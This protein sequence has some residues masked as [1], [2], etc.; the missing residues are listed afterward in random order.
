[1]K[2]LC[3]VG[4]ALT[5]FTSQAYGQNRTDTTFNGIKDF[6]DRV[7]TSSDKQNF[8]NKLTAVAQFAGI[9]NNG[10]SFKANLYQLAA[11]KDAYKTSADYFNA[12]PF[13]RNLELDLGATPTDNNFFRYS[14]ASG[15]FTFAIKNNNVLTRNDYQKFIAAPTSGLAESERLQDNLTRLRQ[16]FPQYKV[17]I[18]AFLRKPKN[19]T[20]PLQL[21][22]ILGGLGFTDPAAILKIPA[23]AFKEIGIKAKARSL[24]TISPFV[25]YDGS[26]GWLS[27]AGIKANYTFYKFVGMTMPLA[28]SIQPSYAIGKDTI[29]NSSY[30]D[31]KLFGGSLSCNISPIV[32][33]DGTAILEIKP[34]FGYTRT[35][36]ELFKEEKKDQFSF[37]TTVS[38]TVGKKLTIPLA[39]KVTQKDPTLFGF[40]AVQYS[41]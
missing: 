29:T 15:G 23:N 9:D 14:K 27:D 26:R 13:L 38:Y 41:L 3:L 12:H 25:D 20:L 7:G 32:D 30:K 2:Y 8:A 36:G 40:L 35:N 17:Q 1:M 39:I 18:D 10:L 22:S 11:A 33:E 19:E 16:Q 21:R 31:R 37:T 4:A 6:F 34:K 24:I 5:L 28:F